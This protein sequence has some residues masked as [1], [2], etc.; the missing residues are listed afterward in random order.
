MAEPIGIQVV[1]LERNQADNYFLASFAEHADGDPGRYVILQRPIEPDEQDSRLGLA[2]CYVETS[3]VT[4]PGYDICRAVI[5]ENKS[6]RLEF[7]APSVGAVVLDLSHA[8]Y[9]EKELK[10]FLAAV[11]QETFIDATSAG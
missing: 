2:G 9:S 10:E 4:S 1:V 3:E 6:L 8:T 11:A 5:L 7:K